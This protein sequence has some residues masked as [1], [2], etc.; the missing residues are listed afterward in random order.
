MCECCRRLTLCPIGHWVDDFFNVNRDDVTLGSCQVLDRW[1][2]MMGITMD[3][4]KAISQAVDMLLLGV[5]L[6]IDNIR[7]CI[8][9]KLNDA[10]A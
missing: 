1:A 9:S 7:K 3:Q 6:A 4:D 10:K 5:D 2:A 8:T